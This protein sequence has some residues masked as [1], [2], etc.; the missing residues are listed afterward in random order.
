MLLNGS[1]NDVE[2]FEFSF[3]HFIIPSGK[4]NPFVFNSLIDMS[5]F[6]RQIISFFPARDS[7]WIAVQLSI[8]GMGVHFSLFLKSKYLLRARSCLWVSPILKPVGNKGRP[9]LFTLFHFQV[10]LLNSL[11][12]VFYPKLLYSFV[13][14]FEYI[15]WLEVIVWISFSKSFIFVCCWN[16]DPVLPSCLFIALVDDRSITRRSS[17][18]LACTISG[19]VKT[20][21]ENGWA[22]SSKP[23]YPDEK[24]NDSGSFLKRTDNFLFS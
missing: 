6:L 23:Q 4:C 10:F 13:S 8:L 15:L 2:G 22:L 14:K 24:I 1:W 21:N 20:K 11:P 16:N 7:T 12:A 17:L 9:H 18:N 3:L 19:F 5:Q